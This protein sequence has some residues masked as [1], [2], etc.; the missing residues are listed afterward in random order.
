QNSGRATTNVV[1]VVVFY[2]AKSHRNNA[3]L[4]SHHATREALTGL[5]NRREFDRRLQELLEHAKTRDGHHVLAYI[6]LD[7][8]KVVNDTCGYTAGD[9]MLRQITFLLRKR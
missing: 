9:R 3:H 7:Q 1:C 6:D 2:C 8:F 5:I 4:L